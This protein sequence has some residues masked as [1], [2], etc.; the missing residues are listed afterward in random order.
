MPNSA[1]QPLYVVTPDARDQAIRIG[2]FSDAT[3][4]EKIAEILSHYARFSAPYTH[5]L[6]N[7]RYEGVALLVDQ[8]VIKKVERIRL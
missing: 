3:P 1:T 8:L 5:N 7:R 2:L 4:D 6:C